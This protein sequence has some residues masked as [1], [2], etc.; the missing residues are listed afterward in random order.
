M[1]KNKRILLLLLLLLTVMLV[2]C[3]KNTTTTSTTSG[4]TTSSTIQDTT[5]TT[6]EV[7]KLEKHLIL[8][9][10]GNYGGSLNQELY[11]VG[12]PLN[13]E[14]D[15][16]DSLYYRINDYYNMKS[17]STRNIFEEF[18][19]YEKTM[20]DSDGIACLIMA[21][22][23]DGEDIVTNNELSL[24]KKY[25][26]LTKETIYGSGTTAEGLVKLATSLGYEASLTNYD[27]KS[28]TT[29][30]KV[31]SFNSWIDRQLIRGKYILVRFSDNDKCSWH[32]IIGHDSM[33]TE[34]PKD[35]VLIL[36]DPSDDLDHYQDGY[37]TVPS[38]R[39][40]RWWFEIDK[41]G[42]TTHLFDSVTISS[43]KTIN[44]T[45]VEDSKK[46][47]QTIPE[48]HLIL[49]PD[50]SYGGSSNI[51]LYGEIP[52]K[53]G[54]TNILYSNY[55]SFLDPYYLKN[56]NNGRYILSG[57]RSFEQTMASSCG[58]CSFLTVL[59]YYGEDVSYYNEVYLTNKYC[60]VNNKNT[61]YNVGIGSTGLQKLATSLDYQAVQ[62][63]YSKNSYTGEADLEFKDYSAFTSWMV[64]NL[65][66]NT[67][68]PIH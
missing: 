30:E 48:L 56:N 43:K 63:S 29:L 50:G 22:N 62:G 53:N 59:N 37:Y 24:V 35:D 51:D 42:N 27:E 4:K 13:G 60:T 28:T 1:A 39:F 45:R 26:E 49:N 9:K 55:Y 14:F 16:K 58:I 10:S 17:S 21:M 31:A 11:G 8:D 66:N 41:A 5:T 46:I 33:G 6:E 23:Y 18:S 38:G 32:L 36:A 47:V 7:K 20:S 12:A 67:P 54:E 65:S 68:L 57:Y 3:G 52:E 34:Y 64:E 61:I 15:V 25:E 19:P 2:G 40:Y 44:F